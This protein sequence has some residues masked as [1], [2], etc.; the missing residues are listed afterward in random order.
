MLD[1]I[2]FVLVVVSER[3]LSTV[4]LRILLMLDAN[5]FVLVIV[6]EKLSCVVIGEKFVCA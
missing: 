5:N 2:N 1:A 4:G 3:L 6:F